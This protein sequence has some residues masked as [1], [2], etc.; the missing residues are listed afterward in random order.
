MQD[1]SDTFYTETTAAPQQFMA[2]ILMEWKSLKTT[3]NWGSSHFQL[4]SSGVW[5]ITSEL[6]KGK[7]SD[8]YLK[9]N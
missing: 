3:Q 6:I 9:A 5:T 7:S 1:E 2:M 8:V 4:F